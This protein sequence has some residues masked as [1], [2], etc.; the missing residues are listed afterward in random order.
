MISFD[1][2]KMNNYLVRWATLGPNA[3]RLPYFS[4]NFNIFFSVD[5][6]WNV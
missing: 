4:Q 6:W 5:D 2:Y 3:L 1:Q